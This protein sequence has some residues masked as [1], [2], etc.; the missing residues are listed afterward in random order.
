MKV[1]NSTNVWDKAVERAV[2]AYKDGHRIVVSFSAGKDSMAVLE[3][4]IEAARIT[5][6]LPVEAW[7]HDEEIMYPGTY[8]YALRVAERKEV[9]M[10]WKMTGLPGLNV[11][12]RESPYW[13]PFDDQ[14]RPDQW[15]RQPPD[16]A[17]R[18]P[19]N[20]FYHVVNP[21]TYPPPAGKFLYVTMGVRATESRRRN[22]MIHVSGGALSGVSIPGEM[23]KG[24][25]LEKHFR[26]IYD[27]TTKDVWLAC[28][29]KGWD[30]NTAYDVMTRFGIS[31][32][33]Q[34]IAPVAM[35]THGIRLLQ[36]ASRAWPEW[37][38]R[39]CVRLPG[40]RLAALY[41]KAALTPVRHRAETWEQAYQRLCIDEAPAWIAKRAEKYREVMLQRHSRHSTEPILEV[42]PCPS[43]TIGRGSWQ[44]MTTN[45]YLGD[46]FLLNT[47]CD[48]IGFL[49]PEDMRPGA[50]TI[51]GK[52][53]F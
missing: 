24:R 48:A 28:K 32:E 23:G 37:F 5:G 20:D 8:E 44:A 39:L 27:W 51:N 14:L 10:D 31:R 7:I 45:M 13:W 6:N 29:E 22:T 47:D 3:V 15:M 35:T 9:K 21:Q 18:V 26:P 34:R 40:V 12:N 46:P 30:Y 11:F 17:I 43:C 53:T 19:Y 38:D 41:G 42:A 52:P 1:Y 25:E 49:E 50:G 16:W 4:M 2:K 33:R 36:M